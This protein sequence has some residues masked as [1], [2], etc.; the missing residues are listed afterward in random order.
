MHFSNNRYFRRKYLL[1]IFPLIISL[2][3]TTFTITILISPTCVQ[4]ATKE[5]LSVQEKKAEISIAKKIPARQKTFKLIEQKR[6]EYEV[7]K[8]AGEV[9]REAERKAREEQ[10]AKLRAE[11]KAEREARV[12]AK[13]RKRRKGLSGRPRRSGRRQGLTSRKG[14]P[15]I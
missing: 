7:A 12:E 11:R 1:F 5:E 3:F 10:K 2:S 15:I 4:A 8:R 14:R 6:E 9:K 13:R